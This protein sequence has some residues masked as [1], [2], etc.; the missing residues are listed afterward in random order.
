MRLSWKPALLSL[1]IA[2]AQ[3]G[4][5]IGTTRGDLVTWSGNARLGEFQFRNAE[6]VVYRCS[7]DD[8]TYFERD[9]QRIFIGGTRQGDRIE[10]LSDRREGSA[11]CYARIVHVLDVAT[12]RAAASVR[13]KPR[14]HVSPTELFAP[15]GDLT[16]AGVVVRINTES[17]LLRT[18]AGGRKTIVLRADTRYLGGGEPLDRNA[19]QLNTP[20][21]IR[22]GRNLDDEIE[23]FQIVWG[24]ILE[25]VH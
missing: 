3:P 7:Y 1:G 20:V 8:K 18:R 25:P 15:R 17:L 11:Q 9:R 6:N 23:A 14:A 22:A 5:P 24:D 10:V 16:F 13:P 2:C 19:L 4:A 21:F 12:V